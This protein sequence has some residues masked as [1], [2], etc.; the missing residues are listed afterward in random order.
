VTAF[1]DAQKELFSD[2]YTFNEQSGMTAMSQV[3]TL[4]RGMVLVFCLFVFLPWELE[5]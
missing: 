5:G 1:C 2:H 3:F 4:T